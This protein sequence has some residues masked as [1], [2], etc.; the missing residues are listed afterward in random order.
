[1]SAQTLVFGTTKVT[2]IYPQGILND[3]PRNSCHEISHHKRQLHGGASGKIRG[4]P[5]S[6]QFT[7]W[8]SWIS[9]PT[10]IVSVTLTYESSLFGQHRVITE[11]EARNKL[12]GRRRRRSWLNAERLSV[13]ITWTRI[14]W[15]MTKPCRVSC[16]VECCTLYYNKFSWFMLLEHFSFGRRWRCS[17]SDLFWLFVFR[18]KAN[19]LWQWLMGLEAEKFDL[20]E[21][22]KRQKYDVS[23]PTHRWELYNND[24]P[25][26]KTSGR[27]PSIKT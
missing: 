27:S 12:R 19:E 18:E 2:T 6:V 14:S 11:E 5:K 23:R 7:V 21:K 13:S 15:S 9:V 4:S 26:G 22:L 1:M 25:N 3:N 10:V 16:L 8:G 17:Y 24:I 20:S